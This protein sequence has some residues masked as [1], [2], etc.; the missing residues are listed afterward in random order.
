MARIVKELGVSATI[1]GKMVVTP[2]DQVVSLTPDDL[3]SIGTTMTGK[4]AQVA[5]DTRTGPQL[6]LPLGPPATAVAPQTTPPKWDDLATRAVQLS[7]QQH[8]GNP[9]IHRGCQP[10]LKVCTTAVLFKGN[11]EGKIIS[12]ELCSFNKFG[13]VRTC[14]DWDTGA[15]HRDMKNNKGEWYK[16]GD[17]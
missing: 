14:V 6:P 17:Q 10:E 16:V 11:A 3:R 12:R 5:P 13:D 9:S 1:I 8:N 4:P 2:P 15:S 7:T